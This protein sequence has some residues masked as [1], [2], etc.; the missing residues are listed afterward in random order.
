MTRWRVRPDGSTWGDFGPDDRW[1]RLNLVGPE[2]VRKG[3]AE[4][5][6]GIVFCLSLPLDRPGGNVLNPGRV[7]PVLRPTLRAGAVTFNCDMSVAV[8]GATDVMCDELVVLPSPPGRERPHPVQWLAA[9][10]PALAACGLAWAT[11]ST[12]FLLF[13]LLSPLMVVATALGDRWHGWRVGRRAAPGFRRAVTVAGQRVDDLLAAETATRLAE[14]P[15]PATVAQVAGL[16]G[17]GVWARRPGDDDWLTVRVGC[18]TQASRTRVR[19]DAGERPAGVVHAVPV[20]ADLRDRPLG[21]SGPSGARGGTA[22]WWVAQLAVHH[23]PDE[24]TIVILT[25]DEAWA[26]ARWLPHV[27]LAATPDEQ[28]RAVE[29]LGSEIRHRLRRRSVPSVADTGLEARSDARGPAVV[30]V[31]DTPVAPAV[32]DLV[33]RG[34]AVGVTAVWSSV[35]PAALPSGC[36]TVEVSTDGRGRVGDLGA[37]L[38]PDLVNDLVT[39]T[40]SVGWAEQLARS[41]APLV[42][43]RARDAERLPAQCSLTGLLGFADVDAATVAEAWSRSTGRADTV[44]G[45]TA[46]GTLEID[47]EADGPH[48]LVAGTTGAGKSELLRSL[49]A[50]LCLRHPPEELAVLLVDYKGGAAFAECAALP[51]TAG[52]VTDLDPHLTARALRSLDAEVRRRELLLRDAGAADLAAY[53]AASPPSPLG[54]L[55]IVVDEFATL[56]EELPDFVPGLVGIAQR[57]RSLGIHLVLATQRPGSV[58]SPQIRANTSLRIALRVTDP[59]ESVDVIGTDDAASITPSTPGRAVLRDGVG[60]RT[61]Q[62]ARPVVTAPPSDAP[63]VTALDARRGGARDG[64]D[65][66]RGLGDIVAAVAGAAVATSRPRV[67]SPWLPPLPDLVSTAMLGPGAFARTDVPDRQCQPDMGVDLDAPESVLVLGTGRSGRTTALASVALAA[68]RTRDVHEVE[69][70]LVDARGDLLGL[71]GGLPHVATC[72]GPG[73]LDLVDTLLERLLAQTGTRSHLLLVDGWDVLVAAIGDAAALGAEQRLTALLRAPG[74]VAVV[75]AGDRSLAAPRFSGAFGRRLALRLGDVTDYGAL[76]IAAR[77]VPVAFPP[78]RGVRAE[79]GVEFQIAV[80]GRGTEQSVGDALRAEVGG[81]AGTTRAAPP[82]R[83]RVRPLPHVVSLDRVGP[84]GHRI[85]IGLGGDGAAPVTLDPFDG[86]RRWLVCGPPRSGRSA[87]LA[88]ALVEAVRLGCPALVAAT[89][90]SPLAGLAERVGVRRVD[91][92]AATPPEPVA[93]TLL[94]VDDVDAF[95]DTDVGDVLHSWVRRPGGQVSVLAS[96]RP[97]ELALAYRGLAA[98]LRRSRSGIVLRPGPVDGE[99]FGVTLP[100]ARAVD[101]PGR[102]R[103]VGDPAWRIGTSAASA[104][105]PIQ[106][107]YAEPASLSPCGGSGDRRPTRTSP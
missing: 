57:G 7:P 98:E 50:G 3:I 102:G 79:D 4:V 35:D 10:V 64:A 103:L 55:V 1:G 65:V 5:R 100:R 70:H 20:V 95:L 85:R 39:D 51:H 62:A 97:D 26:W 21:V 16:P 60:L 75:V 30:L 104:V 90:R 82:D 56:A 44:L 52:L 92:G 8:S 2:Q 72:L 41:L 48:V 32:L 23:S 34:A 36:T 47:L 73:D 9:L 76:G 71:V 101:P 107:A 67:R 69:I 63:R 29:Q 37:A 105:V 19:D 17:V 74:S 84:P 31:A 88:I 53:R 49:V 58:V 43:A 22:R 77:D 27:R 40:V 87:L 18:G 66:D 96:G 94:L 11:G 33:A 80:P 89:S 68:A 28:A 59:G 6:D 15:D 93:P 24:L 83:L 45:R 61:F 54:R 25:D 46:G 13:G 81:L 106:V 91:P 14:F 38:V 78:G 86:P 42:D 99:L 12:V